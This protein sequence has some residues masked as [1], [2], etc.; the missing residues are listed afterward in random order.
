M[1]ENPHLVGNRGLDALYLDNTY[2][3]VTCD[4]P[5]RVSEGRDEVK[6]GKM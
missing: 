1:A 2:C 3:D 6:V 4:F 5:T